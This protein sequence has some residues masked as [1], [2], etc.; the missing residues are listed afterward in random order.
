MNMRVQISG[1]DLDFTFFFGYIPRGGTTGSY[2][3]SI[4]NFWR[5]FCTVFHSD[6]TNLYPTIDIQGSLFSTFLLI[7]LIFCL[8]DNSHSNR[9]EMISH[10][11]FDLHT[12]VYSEVEYLFISLLAICVSSLEKYLFRYLAHFFIR[13]FVLFLYWVVRVF[14]I[15]CILT[16][17]QIYGL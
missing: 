1:W 12:P 11:D 2:G 10:C 4:F 14:D 3:N 17:Y 9:F 8:S 7:V 16:L 13:L 15:F 5:N 6:W